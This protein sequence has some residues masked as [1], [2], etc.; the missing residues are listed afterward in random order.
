MMM[1]REE[2]DC[3][4]RTAFLGGQARPAHELPEA[5]TV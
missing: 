4:S 3:P 5:D 1:V 2:Q